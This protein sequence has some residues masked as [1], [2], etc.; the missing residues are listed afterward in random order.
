MPGCPSYRKNDNARVEQKNGKLIRQ[1]VGSDRL[2]EPAQAELLSS[3]LGARSR[4][5]AGVIQRKK[6]L[7]SGT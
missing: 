4:S 5:L 1:L 7:S 6:T 3:L 2:G